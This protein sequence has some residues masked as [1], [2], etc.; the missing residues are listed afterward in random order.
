MIPS[1]SH[2]TVVNKTIYV[3]VWMC[4]CGC[5]HMSVYKHIIHTK[6]YTCVCVCVCGCVHM[7]VYKHII[8]TK[9]YTCV[10][11]CVH[12]SVYKHIIH[13]KLYTCVCGCVHM[14]VY[15]HIIHTK[16]SCKII[17]LINDL[18]KL[19]EIKFSNIYNKK[20]RSY[21][22]KG[23][24]IYLQKCPCNTIPSFVCFSKLFLF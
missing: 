23:E 15:K 4:T 12:M 24:K 1:E 16:F 17:T 20:V 8:H 7:S 19:K 9:L 11:G 6:L 18:M 2:L 14:S 21:L 5:V 22:N 13:T 10:C 3:C